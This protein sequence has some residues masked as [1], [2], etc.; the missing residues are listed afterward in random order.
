[1]GEKSSY[2]LAKFIV[3]HLKR[4]GPAPKVKA[5]KKATVQASLFGEEEAAV[6]LKDQ[7]ILTP[8]DILLTLE[9][10]S[11]EDIV[12]VEGVGEK[13][14]TEVYE[15]F[16]TASNRA[17]LRKFHKAG[18]T[19]FMTKIKEKKGVTGKSFVLTGSLEKVTRSQAKQLIIEAGGHVQSSVSSKTDYVVAGEKAGSKL[20]KAKEL[21]VK[22]IDE[23]EFANLIG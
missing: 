22:I 17:L 16:K 12:N 23:G 6:D 20:K 7:I 4:E 3:K 5:P 2:D 19:L 14:A 18:L 9:H 21:G 13:V 10:V 1:M 15:W 11:L 8:R